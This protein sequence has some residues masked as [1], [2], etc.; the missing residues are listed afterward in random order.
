MSEPSLNFTVQ[1]NITQF[2]VPTELIRKNFKAIQ[3]LIEKQ[4]R[5]V[6][7]DIAK[8]RKNQ[9]L[10]PS[11]KLELVK[12]LLKNFESFKRKL[13]LLVDRDMCLR[14][15]LVARLE[16]LNELNSYAST[17]NPR[18]NR[19]KID[20]INE[21]END[22]RPELTKEEDDDVFL[23]LHNVNLINWYRE[24]ANLLIVDFL[25]KS[26]KRSES[27][28]GIE[29]LKSMAQSNPRLMDLIDYDL[30]ANLNKVFISILD[31]HDLKHIGEWFNDN[32]NQLKKNGSNLEFEI[33]YCRFLSLIE[34]GDIS[35][36]IRFSQSDLSHYGNKD[37]YQEEEREN[38]AKNLKRLKEI[39]GLLVYM[40]VQRKFDDKSSNYASFSS[41]LVVNS[42]RF[43]GYHKL[44][45]DKRWTD[46]ATCFI[47]NF[48]KIYGIPRNY[49]LF[50]YLS[51]GL[52]SLK[53]KSCYCNTENTTFKEHMN[54]KAITNIPT[55]AI[56]SDKKFRG[57]N[58]YY[59]LL[60][61]INHCPVCSPELYK[62]GENLPYAQ[63]ITSIFNNPFK[64]PNGNIYPIDKL[65]NPSGK[66]THGKTNLLK[67]GRIKDPL[68]H[69]VFQID[70]CVRVYPA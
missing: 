33:N 38:Y 59:R 65:L 8:I 27:N 50:I 36:A 47:E 37:F 14:K 15:R 20:N 1:S 19:N 21:H 10:Q 42:A 22:S 5:A 45:S 63:L 67:I 48:T 30:L 69:E 3:K 57:P 23:E 24:Q 46:L 68:T 61:K 52:S 39:G 64:L 26:N 40:A 53:T 60:K 25:I 28:L 44:L 17:S 55:K 58:Y 54:G 32:R 62:L 56:V 29:L 11:L 7:N 49:P 18:K 13:V 2:K 51:A 4:K 6:T 16:T 41:D 35:R 43:V 70:D 66:D 34:E 12:K 31:G 9:S